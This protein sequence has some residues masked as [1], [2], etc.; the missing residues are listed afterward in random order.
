[1]RRSADQI[2]RAG[3]RY[4]ASGRSPFY[5]YG[6]LN[7]RRAVELALPAEPAPKIVLRSLQAKPIRDFKKALLSLTTSESARLGS[8]AVGVDIDHTWIGDLRVVV[9]A[10]ASLGIGPIVLFDHAEGS[11]QNLKRTYDPS[12]APGLAQCIGRSPAGRWTLEVSDDAARDEGTLRSFSL[13][14]GF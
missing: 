4:D 5:G 12:N 3:G 1:L 8:I 14:L 2:D 7:A 9:R 6:R 11:R 13:D 10:P